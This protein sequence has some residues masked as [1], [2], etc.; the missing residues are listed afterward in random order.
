MWTSAVIKFAYISYKI[1]LVT[2]SSVQKNS[3]RTKHKHILS[4][5]KC[6]EEKTVTVV[7]QSMPLNN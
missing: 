5:S 2:K 4:F 3:L 6:Y 7:H 1:C